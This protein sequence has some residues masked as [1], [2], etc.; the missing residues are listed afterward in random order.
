MIVFRYVSDSV[1]YVVN[2]MNEIYPIP[3]VHIS[4]LKMLIFFSVVSISL[5]IIYFGDDSGNA[6]YDD[7][8]GWYYDDDD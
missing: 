3:D 1:V 5:S 7:D 6:E 4:L 8:I 2:W